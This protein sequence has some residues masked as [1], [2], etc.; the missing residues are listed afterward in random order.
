[1]WVRTAATVRPANIRGR[2]ALSRHSSARIPLPVVRMNHHVRIWRI[3]ITLH[4]MPAGSPGLIADDGRRRA[5]AFN[6]YR[7]C[8]SRRSWRGAL[9]TSGRCSRERG[10]RCGRQRSYQKA[11][12][13]NLPVLDLPRQRDVFAFCS[14]RRVDFDSL[15]PGRSHRRERVSGGAKK[16]DSRTLRECTAYRGNAECV[17]F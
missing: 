6:R 2:R 12:H 11:S 10:N 15:A 1:M 3:V 7:R 14:G 5:V 16:V 13:R 4:R 17:K 8:A 9:S